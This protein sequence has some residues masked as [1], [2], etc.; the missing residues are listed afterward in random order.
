ML[1]VKIADGRMSDCSI[2]IPCPPII[3]IPP[4][5]PITKI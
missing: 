5:S 2:I 1:Y 3:P 4:I